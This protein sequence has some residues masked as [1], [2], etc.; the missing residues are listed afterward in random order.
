M[1]KEIGHGI[2]QIVLQ[3]LRYK[4][5]RNFFKNSNQGNPN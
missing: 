5:L 2:E 1:E 3:K 4:W